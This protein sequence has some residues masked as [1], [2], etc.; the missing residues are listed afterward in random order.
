MFPLCL[1]AALSNIGEQG[2]RGV[3]E[4]STLCTALYLC[5][6]TQ[7]HFHS[8]T[9]ALSWLTLDPE[10]QKVAG[11]VV[12]LPSAGE[13][14]LEEPLAGFS[15]AAIHEKPQHPSV[16]ALHSPLCKHPITRSSHTQSHR[17]DLSTDIKTSIIPPSF[18][19]R[20][21]LSCSW[22]RS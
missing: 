12:H 22:T 9:R 11:P 15:P 20:A 13:R 6:N 7:T 16:E 21:P 19:Y 14:S 2:K 4:R 10:P 17:K 8:Q 18:R 3:R 1:T 5:P